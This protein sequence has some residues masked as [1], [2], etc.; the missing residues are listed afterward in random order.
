MRFSLDSEYGTLREV[1]LCPPTH[2]EWLPTNAIA[3]Q[4]LKSGTDKALLARA[5]GQYGEM[6]EA[7]TSAGV[8]V[9]YL[10]TEP[11]LKYQVYTRDSSQVTPWGPVMTQLYR[12]ERRGEYAAILKFYQGE[13]DGFWR[14]ATEGTVE[15]GDIHVIRPGLLVIGH[16][17]VRTNEAG[18][19]QFAGWFAEQGW[20][21]LLYGFPEHFLHL[22]VIFCMVAEDLACACVEVLD[23]WFL[24]WLQ[25]RKIRLIPVSY[26]DAMQLGCNVL[27]L[28]EGRVISPRHNLELNARMRA[29]GLTVLD[30]ELDV[31]TRGGGGIHCMTMP[32][33]RD[34]VA[35]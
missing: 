18:A 14:F 22:D 2:Y 11:H 28:G 16:S 6:V 8:T 34:S 33:K 26:R 12:P 5:Q 24:D 20:E 4:T 23:E 29:E 30:P 32:L 35:R 10:E 7:L 13:G 21:T 25:A 19:R 9:R 1:L 31:F 27:A 3:E 15:G 17:G